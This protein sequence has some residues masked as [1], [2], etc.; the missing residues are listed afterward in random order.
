MYLLLESLRIMKKKKSNN[1]SPCVKICKYDADFMSA[2]VC[3]GC[4]REQ[5]EITNWRRMTLKEKEQA[6]V[7]IEARKNIFIKDE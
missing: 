1:F 5:S 6:L 4:F 3:V 7:D 2:M